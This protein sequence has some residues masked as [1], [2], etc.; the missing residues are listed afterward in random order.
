MECPSWEE[1]LEVKNQWYCAQM[2][3][4]FPRQFMPF[5]H[6]L[7]NITNKDTF[8]LASGNKTDIPHCLYTKNGTAGRRVPL[9]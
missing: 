5:P 6:R 7:V 3:S 9:N 1:Q 2:F 8:S 4:H